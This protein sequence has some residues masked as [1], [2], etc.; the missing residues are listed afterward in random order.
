MIKAVIFD[1]DGLMF[2]TESLYDIAWEHAGRQFGYEITPE[3][4]KPMRGVNQTVV[5][6]LFFKRF[7]Q[8]FDFMKIRQSRIDYMEQYIRAHGLPHK[9][10]LM[11]LL[12]FLKENGYQI[13]VA[14]STYK[15]PADRYLTTEGIADYFDVCVYG[16][17]AAKSKPDPEIYLEAVQRLGRMPDECLVLEDS[18]NGILA[19][20]NAGCPVIMIP[21]CIQATKEE[22]RRAVKILPS[23]SQV[24]LYLEGSLS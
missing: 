3:D 11:E 14:T 1:M 17:M 4:L 10:G 5:K 23:L 13:A 18:P 9:P 21:D 24:I 12:K 8:D 20:S 16:D 2:D 22:E 6:E 15:D 7:G 19:G